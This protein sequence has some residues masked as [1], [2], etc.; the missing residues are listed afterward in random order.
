MASLSPPFIHLRCHSAFSLAEGA[1]RINRLAELAVK[2]EMPALALTDRNNLFGALE[3]SEVMWASGVQPIIGVT[4]AVAQP[5]EAGSVAQVRAPAPDWLVLLAQNEA[6]Y[7]NLMKLVSKAHLETDA[8]QAPQVTLEDLFAHSDHLIALTGGLDGAIGR[9]LVGQKTE[10]AERYASALKDHFEDRLYIE[11]S[12]HDRLEERQIEQD[13]IA[14]AHKLDL[15]LVATN[16]CLFEKTS[17][18]EAH[19][20]LS[21][22]AAGVVAAR[23]DRLRLTPEYRFKSSREMQDLFRDIPEAIENTA[24]IAQRCA[25]KVQKHPPILPNFAQGSGLSEADM[26]CDKAR[27]GLQGRLDQYIFK[28]EMTDAERADV[29]KPYWDRLDYELGIIEN[30]GFPGYFLIVADFI[31]WSKDQGIPVGPG[32]GSGAGSVVAWALLITNLDPLQ[33]NLLFERFLNPERVSMPDFDIDFCQDRREEVIRYVQEKYGQD[34]VA[35]I[36]TFGKL[37]ARMV[38]RDVGRVIGMSY[39]QVDSLCKLVPNHPARPVTLQQAIDE[40]PKLA[41][42]LKD[43][44]AKRL[45]DLS[46]LLE[47]L[48]R[49]AST[50]AAGVVIGD[51]PLDQL[52]PLYRDPRSDMPV[53]QFDM[54]WVEQAG[55]VKFDF[56]G[57]KTLTVLSN[58]VAFIKERGIDIDLDFIP[59]DD[60]RTYELLSKGESAGVFQLES[61]G[62]RSV[63]TG[64]KPD[65]LEDIIALVALYRPG[66]MDNI[67]AFIDRKHGREKVASLHPML[68]D[69]LAETYGIAVYQEQVMQ[70]AQTLAGYS[71][72]EADLLRRAMG[73]KKKAEMDA[74]R[75]RFIEGAAKNGVD[76]AE[77]NSIF[78]T[79]AKFAGYG[80]NKSHAAAYALVAYQTAYLKA[81]YPVE[82]M[83]ASMNLDLNNTD[84]L[85][86]FVAEAKRI[87]IPVLPPDINVSAPRFSVEPVDV[88][89]M[90]YA[91]VEARGRA[92]RYGLAALK[93][94]GEQAMQ[95][96]TD[97]RGAY[98]HY[99]S[100]YDLGER[101]DPQA[102]N[103][104]MLENLVRGGALDCLNDNRA[105][106]LESIPLILRASNEA[107]TRKESQIV[108]LFEDVD[109]TASLPPLPECKAW[110]P[111]QVLQQEQVAFG[112]Y[113]TAHPLDLFVDDL[114]AKNVQT[115]AQLCTDVPADEGRKGVLAGLITEM[116]ERRTKTGKTFLN[117]RLTDQSGPYEVSFFSEQVEP[118]QTVAL[119]KCPVVINV[120]VDVMAGGDRLNLTGRSIAPL[121]GGPDVHHGMCRVDCT[122]QAD[123]IDGVRAVVNNLKHGTGA[124][125]LYIRTDDD[126]EVE[127]KLPEGVKLDGSARSAFASIPGVKQAALI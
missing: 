4:L 108:S 109:L 40:V 20:A 125:T 94:V 88:E 65:R 45:I 41:E 93:N 55:L 103:K 96:I 26:L 111:M 72:G 52:I 9:L 34:Q 79:L 87:G 30:M 19:D 82:F 32:R 86:S 12:R 48:Y 49:H 44:E 66:P 67:P 117:V 15:P 83:A 92:I 46:L 53:T 116:Y 10:A 90:K 73:K 1:L 6:G 76:E 107:K 11:I 114:A 36:I 35:Q 80:F 31:Q 68:D 51:R 71:L 54:K 57:L 69:I 14:L 104:R 59:L 24:I 121:V 91:R 28:P 50:H 39:G 98:G 89:T 33:F 101:V 5:R 118:V 22:I 29:A 56:L 81:N 3:F 38:L 62:M 97:E 18:F 84:K 77:A 123:V 63:L 119:Q 85:A 102:L 122:A 42:A 99:K 7:G 120:S 95:A 21:C 25:F 100:V 115:V 106:T 70:I 124:V 2:H 61:D 74:Q 8:V 37:Q 127:L 13:V 75:V 110:E 113:L 78:D 27:A 16:R 60:A 58:A 23:K 105:Q 112:F 47:G 17:H 64:L 43:E 126:D